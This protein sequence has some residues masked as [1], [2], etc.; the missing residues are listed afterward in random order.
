[1]AFCGFDHS[2]AAAFLLVYHLTQLTT[3]LASGAVV[4]GAGAL[5]RWISRQDVPTRHADYWESRVRDYDPSNGSMFVRLCSRWHFPAILD[6]LS[7]NPGDRV[8]DAGCGTG[9][10]TRELANR[11]ARVWAFD[12]SEAMLAHVEG[13]ELRSW[14]LGRA[15]SPRWVSS[16][17][18]GR[19]GHTESFPIRPASPDRSPRSSRPAAKAQPRHVR[20]S[21]L[22]VAPRG[23]RRSNGPARSGCH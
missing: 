11:G 1:M 20:S 9:L 12:A 21:P 19:S 10:L 4:L 22:K 3:G 18:L 13:A 17:H 14:R 7:L 8:L 5:A 6:L 23:G 16:N 2:R 15:R